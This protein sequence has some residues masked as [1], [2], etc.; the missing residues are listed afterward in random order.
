MG[1]Q[2]LVTVKDGRKV[3]MKLVCGHDGMTAPQLAKAIK[4]KW[5]LTAEQAYELAIE[6]G[7][8]CRDCLTVI[9]ETRICYESDDVISEQYRKTFKKPRFNPRC[10]SGIIDNYV[11]V[12]IAQ[13]K[14]ILRKKCLINGVV[15]KVFFEGGVQSL[16]FDDNV[17]NKSIGVVKPGTWDFG[18]L[19]APETIVVLT[20]TININGI[21]YPTQGNCPLK[22]GDIIIFKAT[23]VACYLCIKG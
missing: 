7:F 6:C 16:S 12:N 22:A 1:T 9:T 15:H 3:V 18:T 8:G 2:G 20:N 17:G 14:N 19:D 4:E 10:K 11:S 5:P 13:K 23:Q 21:D